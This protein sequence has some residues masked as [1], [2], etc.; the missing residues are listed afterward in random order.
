[1]LQL[2]PELVGPSEQRHIGGMFVVGEAD[3]PA[4]SVRGPHFMSDVIAFE[5]DTAQLPSEPM[6]QRRA[7]HPSNTQH[8]GIIM[9]HQCP[10]WQIALATSRPL[11][12]LSPWERAGV[13]GAQPLD[14]ALTPSP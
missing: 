8:D 12:P 10:P 14:R 13:R 4:Q 7:H 5:C 1:M 11:F 9:G 3:N 2:S 6:V